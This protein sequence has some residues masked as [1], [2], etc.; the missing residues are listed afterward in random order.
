MSNANILNQIKGLVIENKLE[1]EDGAYKLFKEHIQDC[2]ANMR[3]FDTER[4]SG[5]WRNALYRLAE[6]FIEKDASKFLDIVNHEINECVSEEE[7]EALEFIKSEIVWNFFPSDS[8]YVYDYFNEL[9]TRYPCNPEF[10][11]TFSHYFENK[12]DYEKSISE[13]RLALRIEPNNSEFIDSC[14]NKEVRFFDYSLKNNDIESA[15]DILKKIQGFGIYMENT[16]FRNI[17]IGLNHRIS[18]HMAFQVA[19]RKKFKEIDDFVKRVSE[20]ERRKLIEVLGIFASI[21]GFVV[22]NINIAVQNLVLGDMLWLMT[23]MGAVFLIFAISISYIFQTSK[24]SFLK[25]GKFWILI[26]LFSGLIVLST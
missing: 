20:K 22:I 11:H 9:I 15:K 3:S 1:G 25:E 8:E 2:K 23:A 13:C 26:A 10:H 19:F 12:E 4:W 24:K 7:I 18:D 16:I 21:L 6:L 14:F 17:T 5:H